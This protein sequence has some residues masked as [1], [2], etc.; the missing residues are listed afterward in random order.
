MEEKI[1]RLK[2]ASEMVRE[3]R[4]KYN[5]LLRDLVEGKTEEYNGEDLMRL[6]GSLEAVYNHLL[7]SI[8]SDGDIY[9]VLKHLSYSIILAG[10]MEKPDVGPL[11]D[12]LAVVTNGRIEPCSACRQDSNAIMESGDN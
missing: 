2:T 5:N 10:E 1:A 8:A 9:C 12:I 7:A 4:R 6:C 11:Y 3:E